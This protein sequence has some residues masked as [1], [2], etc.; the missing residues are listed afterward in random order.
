MRILLYSDGSAIGSQALELGKRIAVVLASAV[1][2]L[3]IARRA[4]RREA[5][6]ADVEAAV[7]ELRA[8]DIPVKIY[9]RPGLTAREVM[10]Q[11]RAMDYDM[12]V[13][14]SRG[15]RGIRRLIAG[16]RACSILGGVTSSVLVVKGRPREAIHSILLCS[17]AGPASQETAKFAARLARAL[18]ASLEVLHVMSQVALE[19]DAQAAD[20]EAAA[21][22]LMESNT[23]EGI[24]MAAMLEIAAAEG[25]DGEP[26]VRH[27]LVVEEIIAEAQDGHFD[28]LVVGA[29]AT[30]GI[31]GL[32]S[33]DL[34][35]EIM[36]SANRPVLIVRQDE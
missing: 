11:A 1:D 34:A 4:D 22:E 26:L 17:A 24:H 20:L 16:S 9:Q 32:L 15:R 12:V 27:G 35:A 31:E 6:R 3:A 2:I 25:V 28:M 10:G 13:I 19:E 18:G 8:A 29:H 7:K 23:R 14:G 36:L 30:P 33:S 5:A 21:E